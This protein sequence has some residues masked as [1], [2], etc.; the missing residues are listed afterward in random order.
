MGQSCSIRSNS[1]SPPP[2]D[3][4]GGS[5]SLSKKGKKAEEKAKMAPVIVSPSGKHTATLIFLHGL[6]DTGH[7]WA[8]S[9]A[10]VRQSHVK[11]VCPTANTI[12]VT[13]NSGF[14][15]PAWFDLFS[16]DPTGQEDES[17]IEKSKKAITKLIEDEVNNGIDPSRIVLG[18]FSQGGALSL[19]TGLT[20]KYKL[21]GIV[22]LSC[23]LPLHKSFPG[24]L[25][26]NNAEVPIMQ[27]HGDC[28]P[29]VPYRWGQQTSTAVKGFVKN[30]DFKTYKGLSHSSGAAEMQDVQQFLKSRLPPT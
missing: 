2:T 7:G 20:G 14:Q 29:V 16:L 27:A 9:L 3:S 26:S 22:A 10:E 19:Y 12:P 28:D 17:G 8:S 4:A 25:N 6:G 23:W 5:P 15:M 11:I 13:L 18:G 21:A 1:N 30:H 24:A